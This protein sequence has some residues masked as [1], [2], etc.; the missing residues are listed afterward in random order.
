MGPCPL[1]D[2]GL[3]RFNETI[4]KLI[5]ESPGKNKETRTAHTQTKYGFLN[6]VVV[7]KPMDA[8]WQLHC[9][10]VHRIGRIYRIKYLLY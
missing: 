3:Q 8:S 9:L 5:V 2:K 6:K 7:S 4:E 1:S 10:Q